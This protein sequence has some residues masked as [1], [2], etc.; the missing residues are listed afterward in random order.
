MAVAGL[1]CFAAPLCQ[2]ELQHTQGETTAMTSELQREIRTGSHLCRQGHGGV[3]VAAFP[4][5]AVE[6]VG[7]VEHAAAACMINLTVAKSSS[8]VAVPVEL[9]RETSASSSQSEAS[10]GD[11]WDSD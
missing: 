3:T 11:V 10:W 8:S 5:A 4:H 7:Q 1:S 2:A 6:V 9:V